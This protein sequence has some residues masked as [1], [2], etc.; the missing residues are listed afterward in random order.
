MNEKRMGRIAAHLT[1]FN[2]EKAFSDF[3]VRCALGAVFGSFGFWFVR[4]FVLGW[5]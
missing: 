4:T 5:N 1:F 2:D 3:I